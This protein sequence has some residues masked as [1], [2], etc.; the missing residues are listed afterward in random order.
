MIQLSKVD[1]SKHNGGLEDMDYALLCAVPM[2]QDLND[3]GILAFISGASIKVYDS[4]KTIF[5]KGESADRFFVILD[6][7]VKLVRRSPEGNESVISLLTRG[8]TFAEAAMFSGGGFPVDAITVDNCRLLVVSSKSV[9]RAIEDDSRYAL[10]VI[11]SM[12]R[13]MRGLVRQI[14]QLSVQSSTERLANFLLRLCP[15]GV[16]KCTVTLPVEKALLA[17]RLGMQPETF[18][19]SLA[20]LRK[21]GIEIKGQKITIP[22][23]A[24]LKAMVS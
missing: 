17:A 21:V 8:E 1:L 15:E 4:R 12:S 16:T 6:G 19:R 10:N 22:D 14:E 24:I 3:K 23:V 13:H 11:A 5:E 2:F 7:W 9:F 20:K 18:S